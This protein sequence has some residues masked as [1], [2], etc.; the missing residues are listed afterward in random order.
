MFLYDKDFTYLCVKLKPVLFQLAVF[1]RVN[2]ESHEAAG[3][4][5][6]FSSLGGSDEAPLDP[7]VPPP[8]A[9]SLEIHWPHVQQKSSPNVAEVDRCIESLRDFFSL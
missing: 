8:S 9:Y 6:N 2:K 5:H 4:I 1:L 7:I 3:A